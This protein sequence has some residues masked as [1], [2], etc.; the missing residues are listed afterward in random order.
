MTAGKSIAL[1]R[2]TCVGKVM[3]LLSNM[4]S[5]LVI[6]FLPRSKCLLI[7]WLQ[8]PSTVILE[9]PKYKV[10]H[11]FPIYLPWSDGTRY[12]DL[13]FKKAVLSQLFHSPLSLSSSVYSSLSFCLCWTL[14]VHSCLLLQRI[15][16]F[17]KELPWKEDFFASLMRNREWAVTGW[18]NDSCLLAC[19]DREPPLW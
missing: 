15:P 16:S 1:T 14:K 7:S 13:S 19:L 9:L 6:A 5:R 12:H 4:P 10:S 2:W 11:C 17:V 3:S 8:S 18:V